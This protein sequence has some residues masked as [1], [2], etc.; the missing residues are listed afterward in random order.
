MQELLQ[1][2]MD[3]HVGYQKGSV[4]ASQFSN[5]RNGKTTK[6]VR[7]KLG[8]MTVEVPVIAIVL[9]SRR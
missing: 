8:E 2:E 7:S 5:S 4:E 6:K 3:N 1:A 9:L